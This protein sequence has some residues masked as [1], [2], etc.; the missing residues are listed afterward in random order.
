MASGCLRLRK[1]V[2]CHV[3]DFTGELEKSQTVTSIV[4][5][6]G[7]WLQLL[8]VRIG[9][10]ALAASAGRSWLYNCRVTVTRAVA[11][12]ALIF[13]LC[14]AGESRAVQLLLERG[15]ASVVDTSPKGWKPLHFAAAAGHVELCAM[16]IRGGADKSALV[17][18]G[19]TES[20]LSPISLFVLNATD[21]RAED[22]VQMLRL[23]YDCIDLSEAESDGWIVHEGLKK[24][25]AKERTEMSPNSITWL[26]RLSANE[27]YVEFSARTLWIALQHSVRSVLNHGYVGSMLERILDI[28][29][30]E[31]Q[32]ISRRQLDAI[33]AWLALRVSGRVLLPMILSAGSFLQMKGFDWTDDDLSHRSFMQMLPNLYASWC[34]AVLDAVDGLNAYM[35]EELEQCL[36]QLGL[37]RERFL[38]AISPQ[39]TAL[40]HLNY[41]GVQAS[42]CTDCGEDYTPLKEAL[43]EPARIAVT[44]C[45]VTGHGSN[46]VCQSVSI[47]NKCT[48]RCEPL[49]Y[50][51]VCCDSELD[52]GIGMDEEFFDAEPYLFSANESA[53][54]TMF[55]GIATLLYRA[56]GRVWTGDYTIGERLCAACFLLREQYIGKDGLSADFPPIPKSF[57]GLRVK[58]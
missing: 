35:R 55:S 54:S 4:F 37:T 45:V 7:R 13:E 50:S 40:M 27:E 58:W 26:L 15:Q 21:R 30:E 41:D 46:C 28:S 19:P 10:E 1:T 20:V 31:H 36:G 47:Q 34:H 24:A 49:A 38:D 18:E 11:E 3:N 32:T 16:L 6:P 48:N 33:C 12:D 23:F 39:N 42:L 52:K 44:E 56:Q 5:Y 53:N 8:G 2:I 9:F 25:Y 17:Y 57:Q 43:M 51:G 29:I 22:K 14:S